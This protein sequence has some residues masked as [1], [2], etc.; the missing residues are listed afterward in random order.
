ME[1]F[2]II[3]VVVSKLMCEQ[4]VVH[5]EYQW[6]IFFSWNLALE[7]ITHLKEKSSSSS[8]Y[9]FGKEPVRKAWASWCS[10]R[11]HALS[12]PNRRALVDGVEGPTV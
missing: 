11:S 5:S 7:V 4:N 3:K 6:L 9:I 2:N 1:K 10:A 8:Q 12:S